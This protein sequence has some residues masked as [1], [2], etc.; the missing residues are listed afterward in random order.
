M[1]S[2]NASLWHPAMSWMGSCVGWE[3]VINNTVPFNFRER[4]RKLVGVEIG[5]GQQQNLPVT[6]FI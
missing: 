1:M 3:V 6:Y 5:L 4:E 2:A